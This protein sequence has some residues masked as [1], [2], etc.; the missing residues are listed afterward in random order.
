MLPEH[1][2]PKTY[3]EERCE[4]LEESVERLV[5]IL[6]AY[7]MPPAGE[8]ALWAHMADWG[9]LQKELADKHPAPI[10]HEGEQL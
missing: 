2:H 8:Q 5:R 10:P 1:L 4:L 7:S 6:S 3:W 9:R